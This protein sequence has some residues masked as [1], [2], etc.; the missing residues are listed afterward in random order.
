M[1]VM[2]NGAFTGMTLS[3]GGLKPPQNKLSSP[4]GISVWD[5]EDDTAYATNV[6]KAVPEDQ[7][8]NIEIAG[9]EETKEGYAVVYIEKSTIQMS[10]LS[11]DLVT[12]DAPTSLV[13]LEDGETPKRLKTISLDSDRFALVF[14][15]WDKDNK[16]SYTAYKVSDQDG[17][18]KICYAMRLP[19]FM[20]LF[21]AE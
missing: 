7:Q 19:K 5:V 10:L 20:P 13:T 2:S 14:E 21:Q 6:A 16:Y 8:I 4:K 15:V 17:M 1:Q 12:V 3:E 9:I 18:V 11:K